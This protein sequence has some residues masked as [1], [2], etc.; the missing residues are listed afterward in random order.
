MWWRPPSF[1]S[2]FARLR[3][4]DADF[5]VAAG[6]ELAGRYRLQHVL[7]VGGMGSV[8]RAIDLRFGSPVAVKVI[9]PVL[10]EEENSRAR[11]LLEAKMAA[12]LRSPHVVQILDHGETDG[13]VFIVMELLEGESLSTRLEREQRLDATTTATVITHI[14]RAMT[15]ACELGVTHRDLK[16]DNVFLVDND[17]EILTK[18][19]D[20]GVAKRDADILEMTGD[21]PETKT[22]TLLGTPF[23]MSPEQATAS[24]NVDHRSDLWAMAVITYECLLGERPYRTNNLGD[25]I[26]Q[27]CTGPRPVPSSV[28]DVPDGF[29]AWFARA[30]A[31]DAKERFQSATDLTRGLR[32]ILLGPGSP[33][34]ASM[35]EPNARSS[36]GKPASSIDAYAETSGEPLQPLFGSAHAPISTASSDLSMDADD[37]VYETLDALAT[38][39]AAVRPSWMVGAGAA[40]LSVVVGVTAWQVIAE[41]PSRAEPSGEPLVGRAGAVVPPP[42]D[43]EESPPLD[44]HPGHESADGRVVAS[45]SAPSASASSPSPVVH[46]PRIPAPLPAPTAAPSATVPDAAPRPAASA[47]TPPDPLAI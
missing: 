16:P 3:G 28:G 18:V 31:V 35:T 24:K 33:D 10:A 42:A 47:S 17:G 41:S 32:A 38:T 14:G 20:F 25:L 26:L 23:Y 43:A 19:L 22:G 15:R 40:L 13:C 46:R 34:E 11:F 27:I 39:R 4:S 5:G 7:G 45:A 12:R 1:E 44:E 36:E 6:D 9:K 30:Q 2:I 37:E 8:W 29:D 21:G